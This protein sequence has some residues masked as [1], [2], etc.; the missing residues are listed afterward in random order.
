MRDRRGRCLREYAH[1]SS[2]AAVA[3]GAH[4]AKL[5]QASDAM[6]VS[7]HLH[8]CLVQ[9]I[10]CNCR[11]SWQSTLPCIVPHMYCPSH[12]AIL[13]PLPPQYLT[14]D[15][16]RLTLLQREL[17][18][19]LESGTITKQ[20]PQTAA[21]AAKKAAKKAKR[22]AVTAARNVQSSPSSRLD[23]SQIDSPSTSPPTTPDA[24]RIH[25]DRQ[26]AQAAGVTQ[27]S[28]TA[29]S[30][31]P[32]L[33]LDSGHAPLLHLPADAPDVPAMADQQSSSS[34]GTA[35]TSAPAWGQSPAAS[36][37]HATSLQ[38]SHP[39]AAEPATAADD[40]ATA[41]SESQQDVDG[42]KWHTVCN[43]RR[44]R[45]KQPAVQVRAAATCNVNRLVA[46]S[47]PPPHPQP[48]STCSPPGSNRIL[49]TTTTNA[50]TKLSSSGVSLDGTC[51]TVGGGTPA[52]QSATRY[53]S[54]CSMPKYVANMLL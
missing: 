11:S 14:C 24:I 30:P 27:A 28:I 43:A 19:S 36:A 31:P 16:N 41:C 21:K 39:F 45:S 8:F 26:E 15:F 33:L 13:P 51:S 10:T 1:P 12:A 52:A 3:M 54:C 9:P 6:Q 7:P 40:S 35:L 32:S 42:E 50:N 48:S 4:L 44:T 47:Q 49:A 38:C 29:H 2:A 23:V 22:K 18:G 37:G 53:A 20:T 46:S 5:E 34:L 17:L 25:G